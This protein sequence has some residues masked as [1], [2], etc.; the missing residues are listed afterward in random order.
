MR[1]VFLDTNILID[2]LADRQPFSKYAIAIFTLAEKMEIELYMS[3]ISFANTHYLLKKHIGDDILRQVLVQLFAYLKIVSLNQTI[4]QK[5]LKSNHK[6]FEDALQMHS[7]YEILDLYC[8]VTRN[9]KDFKGCDVI[10]FTPEDFL[11]S[12]K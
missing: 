10:V 3:A 6:D 9:I 2:L 7:S 8:I 12:L 5:S 4:I 11:N 1:K